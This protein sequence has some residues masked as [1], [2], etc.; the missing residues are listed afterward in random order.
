MKVILAGYQAV[1]ILQGGPNTQIRETVK[2]LRQIGIDAHLFD[3]WTRLTA[4]DC[5]LVHIV[6]ANIGTFHLAREIHELGI[7]LVASPILYSRHSAAFIRVSLSL[8]RLIRRAGKGIWTDYGL[9]RDV[10]SWAGLVLPNTE[11]EARLV[12][13]G[14]R[15]PRSRI[16]VVPNGADSRF[17]DADPSLFVKTHGMQDFILCVGHTGHARKNVLRL[18]RALGKIDHPAVIVGRIIRNAYGDACAREAGKY[19]HIRLLDAFEH[20]SGLLASAYAACGVFVLPS[21]F[22]T[23]GIAALEAGLAGAKVVITM[24][25]G[26]TEYF[27]S[28]ASYVDPY[29]V[30]SIRNGIRTALAR[31]KDSLLREHIRTHF[32]WEHAARATAAAYRELVAP[33]RT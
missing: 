14:L 32:L 27:G 28:M 20:G 7:P 29:S 26:T 30:E 22:E 31:P 1:S 13:A 4:T 6:A 9:A 18:I 5:D 17:L 24:Y 12:S 33:R 25:G 23:P 10:C 8:T 11:A 2:C 21:E 19:R 16:R 3:P 15:V